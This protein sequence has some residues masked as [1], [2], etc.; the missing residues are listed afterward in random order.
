MKFTPLFIPLVQLWT[1]LISKQLQYHGIMSREARG[2]KGDTWWYWHKLEGELQI[3]WYT[4]S[5][6]VLIKHREQRNIN[7]FS[8][9]WHNCTAGRYVNITL[10]HFTPRWWFNRGAW[11][12]IHVKYARI[13]KALQLGG[14]LWK[15]SNAQV[16]IDVDLNSAKLKCPCDD[17]LLIAFKLGLCSWS[18]HRHFSYAEFLLT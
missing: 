8:W 14:K 15:F 7:I 12:P 17:D 16:P 3:N 1:V 18:D 13:H 6:C 2:D 9:N 5:D 11:E 4:I 10:L